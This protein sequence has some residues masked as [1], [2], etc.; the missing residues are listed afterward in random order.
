MRIHRQPFNRKLVVILGS[1]DAV[2]AFCIIVGLLTLW[3]YTGPLWVT[4]LAGIAV[5]A[6]AAIVVLAWR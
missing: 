3:L 5:V 1:D 4:T 6:G 2:G